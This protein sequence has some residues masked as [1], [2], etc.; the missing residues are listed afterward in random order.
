MLDHIKGYKIITSV[1]LTGPTDHIFSSYKL[2]NE[3]SSARTNHYRY[4][5]NY[6]FIK[7]MQNRALHG[8][9]G[10]PAGTFFK[11]G[12]PPGIGPSEISGLQIT[13]EPMGKTG[14]DTRQPNW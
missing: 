7:L 3:I 12:T 14:M 5:T 13:S 2:D 9:Q 8:A 10:A 6:S 1:K 4:A 11:Q